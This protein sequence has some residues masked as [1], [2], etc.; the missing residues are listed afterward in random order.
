MHKKNIFFTI[1][2]PEFRITFIIKRPDIKFHE[3]HEIPVLS[4]KTV[5]NLT[6]QT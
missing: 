4:M 2:E 6:V 3:N 1:S 5:K